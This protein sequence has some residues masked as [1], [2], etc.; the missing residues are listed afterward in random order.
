MSKWKQGIMVALEDHMEVKEKVCGG[1]DTAESEILKMQSYS[2]EMMEQCL[3]IENAVNAIRDIEAIANSIKDEKVSQHAGKIASIAVESIYNK[4][5]ITKRQVPSL[6]SF[7]TGVATEGLLDAAELIWK[8]IIQAIK[9]VFKWIGEFFKGLFSSNKKLGDTTKEALKKIEKIEKDN[10]DKPKTS[11]E[12]LHGGLAKE[13]TIDGKFDVVTLL[14]SLGELTDMVVSTNQTVLSLKS[15]VAPLNFHKDAELDFKDIRDKMDKA[16]ELM[17]KNKQMLGSRMLVVEGA[18]DD[19]RKVTIAPFNGQPYKELEKIPVADTV[20]LKEIIKACDG[21]GMVI[22]N[23]EGLK[24]DLENLYKKVQEDITKLSKDKP[25]SEDLSNLL[26][27]FTSMNST[28][29]SAS[30]SMFET[31]TL[32]NKSARDYVEKCTEVLQK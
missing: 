29:V 21:I 24:D 26:K 1:A 18:G 25:D 19:P 15:I 28:V 7:K 17:P 2:Q 12:L 4:V 14:K 6:E 20:K 16:F 27:L 3:A 5:G 23:G 10:G 9:D 13:L 11:S 32:I 22:Q 8:K 31:A 30:K